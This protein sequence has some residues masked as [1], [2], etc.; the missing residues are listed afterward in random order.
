MTWPTGVYAC[1]CAGCHRGF[2]GVEAFDRHRRPGRVCLEP[3]S[4][5]LWYATDGQWSLTQRNARLETE[6]RSA[7]GRE[8][9]ARFA[10]NLRTPPRS[11]PG[12]R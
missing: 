1:E 5:G 11:T 6:Q 3:S 12:C 9:G 2:T 8:F 4:V 7:F 10:H